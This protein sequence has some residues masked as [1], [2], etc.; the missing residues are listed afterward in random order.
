MF[1]PGPIGESSPQ[2][3]SAPQPQPAVLL[4]WTVTCPSPAAASSP[5]VGVPA[6]PHPHPHTLHPLPSTHDLPNHS[7]R[8]CGAGQQQH[9]QLGNGTGL[10]GLPAL[11]PGPLRCAE[12][13][14]NQA[15]MLGP[16]ADSGGAT[17]PRPPPHTTGP[18]LLAASTTAVGGAS[19]C[20]LPGPVASAVDGAPWSLT[21]LQFPGCVL[22][23]PVHEATRFTQVLLVAWPSGVPKQFP[24]LHSA[25]PWSPWLVFGSLHSG[26]RTLSCKKQRNRRTEILHVPA[27]G[28][29]GVAD[30]VV[31]ALVALACRRVLFQNQRSRQ[32]WGQLEGQ[33][34]G[35]AL[36]HTLLLGHAPPAPPQQQQQ[37][38]GGGR[39]PQG[40]PA[41]PGGA[42][43]TGSLSQ[44]PPAARQRHV[45]C[46][47]SGEQGC[48][49]D[50]LL[51]AL[52]AGQVGDCAP[53]GTAVACTDNEDR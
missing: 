24:S 52:E 14:D 41:T 16:G 40:L 27:L 36:L 18:G 19:L 47:A 42:A 9:H 25:R 2:K 53:T 37:A 46:D 43:P 1:T 29:D 10:L 28:V 50:S 6:A 13:G 35:E 33:A 38:L 5:C 7:T 45:A 12:A 11:R 22:S 51:A 15:A 21:L 26:F 48:L 8:D 23:Q 32:Y 31:N 44:Q 3:D 30:D 34:L 20:G 49:L 4:S 39:T 17:C